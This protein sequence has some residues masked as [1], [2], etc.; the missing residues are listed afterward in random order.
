MWG[1]VKWIFVGTLILLLLLFIGIWGGW[2]F[3][4]TDS[5]ANYV[6]RK[7][8]ANLQS[9]LG[10]GVEIGKVTFI[11]E[12]P[13]RIVI[14]NLRIANAPGATRPYFATVRQVIITGGVES[15]W[16][17]VIRLGRIELVDPQVF[18]EVFP[19]G[20]TLTHNWPRWKRSPPRRFEITRLEIT[21][22]VAGGGLF[23]FNDR[24]HDIVGVVSNLSA[25]V[26]PLFRKGI[27]EGTATS[28]TAQVRIKDY[29]PFDLNLRGGFYYRPGSLS[30]KSIALRGQGIEAY[31]SGLVDPLSDAVYNLKVTSRTELTRVREIF[32]VEK[33]LAGLLELDGTLRGKR[34]DF[35]LDA[36]LAVPELLADTYELGNLRGAVHITD[37]QTSLDLRSADY[38]GGKVSADY[39]LSKYAEPYP[40][41]V[42]LRYDGISV[43]KLFADW[44]V[45]DTG[46]RGGASGSLH[47]E[48]NK[49]DVLSGHGEGNAVLNRGA[50]AFGN[51]RYPIPVAGRTRFA[52][53]R[54]VI[55]FAPSTLRTE[56]S[57]VAFD[58]SLRIE[59]LVADLK[60]LVNSRDFSELDRI[61]YNFARSAGK[62][63]YELLGLAGA[64]TI[65]GTVRGAIG[66]PF[67]VAHIDGASLDYNNVRLGAADIDLRYDGPRGILTFDRAIFR[68]GGASLTMV[69]TIGFPDRGP[70]PRF[71]L[72]LEA[73]GW[74]VERTLQVIELEM[75]GLSGIGTGRLHVEG[76]PDSGRVDFADLRIVRDDAR[77]N[78][79]GLLAW[80]PGEGNST[81]DLDVGAE[82]YPVSEL[83]AFLEIKNIP[84]SGALTG[85]LHLEGPKKTLAG[86][87]NII[88]R[89]GT[90]M[91]EPIELATADLVFEQGVMKATHVEVRS[92][93]GTVL[94]EAEV[95]LVNERFSYVIRSSEVDIARLKAF[96]AVNRLFGGRLRITSSGA[97]TF[98]N[99]EVVIEA[100]L[101]E[102]AVRGVALPGDEPPPT[103]Y[104]ATREGKLVIRG[105]GLNAFS[106]TGD[107][108]IAPDGTLDGTARLEVTDVARLLS[109]FLPT[110]EFPGSG[111][112]VADLKL[113]GKLSPLEALVVEATIPT[114]DVQ[115]SEHHVTAPEPIRMTLQNGRVD[116]LSWNVASDG[117]TFSAD[118]FVSLVGQKELNLR[119]SGLMEAA[120]VQ[121]F[122]PDVRADGHVNL[123]AG[124]T[125]TLD[126]PRVEGTAEI[127]DAQLK[128][129]GF[130]QLIDNITGTLVFKGD[131]VELDA[132]TASLGGGTIG[133]G[134]FIVLD[135]F[136]PQ[137]VRLNVT[138]TDVSI[139]YF[140]GLT[141][142]GDVNLVLS[143][144]ME[145]MVLQGDV[146]VDRAV[147]YKDIDFSTQ[148]LTLLLE[149]KGLIP[150]VAASWQDRIAMRIHLSAEDTI[151]ISNNIAQITGSAELDVTGTLA[152][153]VILGLI[154]IDEGGEIRLQDKEYRVVH[155]SINFQNPFQT[156]PYFDVTAE[157]R[158]G[159]YE[160][161]ITLT[162]TLD[163]L[164]PTITSDPPASDW[165]LLTLLGIDPSGSAQGNGTGNVDLASLQNFSTSILVQSLGS[166]LGTR[167]LPFADTVR[168][169]GLL[170]QE[171]PSVTFEKQINPDLR[172]IVTYFTEDPQNRNVEVVEWQ[173]TSDWVVQFTRDTKLGEA[174]IINALSARFR[175]R[176]EGR[177]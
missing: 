69:G 130:P 168:L 125:G 159:D 86:A 122:N 41:K 110:S 55:T 44:N 19:E 20:Q 17:R 104:F 177:W 103:L 154:D 22:L 51:A 147:Y 21:K 25:D 70:S 66:E 77:L 169:E 62:N 118:G 53:N 33:E 174:V 167:I 127:R 135:G 47:Y 139:R 42:D 73:A 91:G 16:N 67:V 145:R 18:F 152:K 88:I 96:A 146:K 156:D 143:G 76:T 93:A 49:D 4:G 63:D 27:Y 26:D 71:D 113:G 57:D 81:F 1:C 43:E 116:L 11:R 164:N 148:L 101:V 161:T 8:E 105:S 9:H 61:G 95:D 28:P 102:G 98:E 82:S 137:T 134:G 58:G 108:T 7:I 40:M 68:D 6:K 89:N 141:I 90:I 170:Q 78:L 60:V 162:G 107:G 136:T 132:L 166:L 94:G 155:G 112:F 175:R 74:P 133:A 158:Q 144:D 106:I 59:N 36:N 117:S 31:F 32:R 160:L 129:A 87:G 38:G 23:H 131:R 56:R 5:F 138:G 39:L 24:R 83:L 54:G 115:I 97:G 124:I 149:R 29:E 171:N 128:L 50:V 52:L 12:K 65:T 157:S 151:A 80:E 46:L 85:T 10:R 172:V 173:V 121:L 100:T 45:K 176:Y 142:D 35:Q 165:T 37:E 3:L 150:E 48:W 64:G 119:L 126:R 14:E 13:A 72:N 79:N 123:A 120:I 140:E 34:G 153:P 92:P 111:K 109:L 114:L 99:P 2:Q 84:V 163:R 15:F 30:L 75:P